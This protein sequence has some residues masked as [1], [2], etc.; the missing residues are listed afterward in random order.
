M[1]QCSMFDSPRTQ[2]HIR[3]DSATDTKRY[4]GDEMVSIR[5]YSFSLS[6]LRRSKNDDSSRTA[7]RQQRA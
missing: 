6:L 7:L 3:L 5:S 1:R 2:N 4:P